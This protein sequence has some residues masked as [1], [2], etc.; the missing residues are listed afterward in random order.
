MNIK[1]TIGTVLI[2]LAIVAFCA[3]L[4]YVY[5]SSY[6]NKLVVA[7]DL[8][9]KQM[10]PGT[11]FEQKIHIIA[12]SC[13]FVFGREAAYTTCNQDLLELHK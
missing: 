13:N 5:N 9:N 6:E 3:T 4:W 10:V 11:T 8:V 7:N 1:K 2:L 12:T